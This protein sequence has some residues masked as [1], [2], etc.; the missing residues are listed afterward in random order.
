MAGAAFWGLQDFAHS[1]GNGPADTLMILGLAAIVLRFGRQ[2][3]HRPYVA[4]CAAFGA[5]VTY[6][7]FFMGQLLTAAALLLPVG[8]FLGGGADTRAQRCGHWRRAISGV[9]AFVLGAAMTIVV[10]QSLAYGYFGPAALAAFTTNLHTYTQNLD[11]LGLSGLDNHLAT[12]IYALGGIIWKWGKVLSYGS[13]LAS[14]LLFPGTT[15]AW[16][17]AAIIAW[18]ARD[19]VARGAFLAC[20]TG[21]GIVVAWIA[22]SPTHSFGHVWFM[23]RILVAPIVLGWAARVM[24]L[25]SARTREADRQAEVA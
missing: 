5:V 14:R 25:A 24:Q 1:L 13:D 19:V 8:W 2:G 3:R 20:V 6:M 17:G 22:V 15:F 21:A 11:Q 9:L 4:W 18:R 12:A 7:E 16:C 10:K 23:V